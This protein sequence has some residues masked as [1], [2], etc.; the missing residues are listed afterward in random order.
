MRAR[1]LITYPAGR[2]PEE[3][4]VPFIPSLLIEA[5]SVGL[6][7]SDWVKHFEGVD[8]DL[9]NEEDIRSTLRLE[10]STQIYM[11]DI[12]TLPDED[13]YS[14]RLLCWRQEWWQREI[15]TLHQRRILARAS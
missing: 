12:Q 7:T 5:G 10:D 3:D 14:E 1:L 13:L 2:L 8:L 9:L 15:R 11:S 6:F 4:E